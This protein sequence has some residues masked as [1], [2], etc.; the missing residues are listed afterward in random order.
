AYPQSKPV[1]TYGTGLEGIPVNL[2]DISTAQSYS[3]VPSNINKMQIIIR[4]MHYFT[5]HSCIIFT[6]Y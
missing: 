5:F 4:L 6:R 3:S 1:V 2:L